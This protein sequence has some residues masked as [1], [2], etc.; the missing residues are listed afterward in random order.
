M[1]VDKELVKYIA[2]LSR[3]KLTEKELEKFPLQLE[4]IL[5]YVEKLDKVDVNNVEPTSHVLPLKNVYREDK[6]KKSID[7]EEVMKVAPERQE[8]FFKVPRVIEG[9]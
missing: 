6:A 4:N 1:K 3:I 8:N 5:A 7:I 9:A 2:H